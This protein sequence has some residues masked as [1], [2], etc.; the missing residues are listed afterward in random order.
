M[1]CG[2]VSRQSWSYNSSVENS[3]DFVID[4]IYR[5]FLLICI[6][7]NNLLIFYLIT[8][9]SYFK[10]PL[11]FVAIF[12]FCEIAFSFICSISSKEICTT[13]LLE[14]ILKALFNS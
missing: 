5:S 14:V 7:S 8:K 12:V 4:I 6:L 11:Y 3:L 1:N 2:I 13:R 10:K 9:M